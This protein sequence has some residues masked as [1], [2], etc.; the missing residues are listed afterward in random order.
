M[1]EKI[2]FKDLSMDLKLGFIGGFI[3]LAILSMSFTWGFLIGIIYLIHY[4]V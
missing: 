1:K 4:V 3:Y 2:K